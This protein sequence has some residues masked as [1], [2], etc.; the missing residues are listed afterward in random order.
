MSSIAASFGLDPNADIATNVCKTFVP[1]HP[2][3]SIIS[4]A[5]GSPVGT[6]PDEQCA[7]DKSGGSGPY[8]AH[9][10]EDPSLPGHT[11]YTPKEP[12]ANLKMPVIV[13]GNGFCMAAGTMFV[14][15]L[16]EIASHGFFIIANGPATGNQLDGTTS[17]ADLIKSVDWAEKNPAAKKWNLDLSKLAVAG[18][19]CGGGQA[20]SA[21]KDSRFKM[22]VLFNGMAG[23]PSG[24]VPIAYF[25]GGPKD[26]AQRVGDSGF[27]TVSVP[28]LKATVDVG[29][30]GTYYQKYGG[31]FG[32]AAVAFFK[33]QQKGDSASKALFCSPASSEL[34]K[35]G[36]KIESRNGMC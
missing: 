8:N 14:N 26:I 35:V 16:N 28:A 20:A 21:S 19:S 31:K 11:I 12:P 6:G 23:S 29:H 24:K 15:F 25:L 30:I 36:F 13:W 3:G 17:V 18:Q 1:G 32:R 5:F 7:V 22:V 34:T 33:W 10:I 4:A 27:K 9:Y 2:L